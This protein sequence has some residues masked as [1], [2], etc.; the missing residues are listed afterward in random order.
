MI[1]FALPPRLRKLALTLHVATSV[2]WLGAVVVFLVLALSGLAEQDAQ[3]ASGT[4]LAL[5]L[6]ARLAIVPLCVAALAS[7]LVQSLGTEWGIFRHWWVV[8]KLL[9]T[10]VSAL[11]LLLHL[12]PVADL[13]AVAREGPLAPG[14]ARDLRIQVA[15]DAGAALVALLAA[16]ALSVF[17]PKGLTRHGRRLRRAGR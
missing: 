9:L 17:K 8:A 12:A 4:Y 5:D 15:A 10:V 1:S 7:G 14:D 2:G 16:T 13:A 11:L 6:T 3:T